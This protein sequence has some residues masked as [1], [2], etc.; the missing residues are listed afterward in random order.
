[1][2]E[3]PELEKIVGTTLPSYQFRTSDYK[4]LISAGASTG[5]SAIVRAGLQRLA[6]GASPLTEHIAS[7][8]GNFWSL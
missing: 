7:S 5:R 4:S 3:H 6:L 2:G 8:A 1:M